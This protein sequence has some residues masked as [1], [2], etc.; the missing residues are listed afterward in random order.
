LLLGYG[1]AAA[2]RASS[3]QQV[4]LLLSA[5]RQSGYRRSGV[6]AGS[7]NSSEA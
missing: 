4:S 5:G 3:R 1:L 2:I 6:G 7:C